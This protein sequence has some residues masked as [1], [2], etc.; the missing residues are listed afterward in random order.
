MKRSDNVRM[1]D[2]AILT[3]LGA[4]IKTAIQ[5]RVDGFELNFTQMDDASSS[6]LTK[7]LG[8]SFRT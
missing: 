6:R 7:V 1:G 8:F 2:Q 4:S 5:E 3:G